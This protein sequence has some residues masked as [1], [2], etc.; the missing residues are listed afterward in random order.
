MLASFDA[1]EANSP[2]RVCPEC[3]EDAVVQSRRTLEEKGLDKWREEVAQL[4]LGTQVHMLEYTMQRLARPSA[5]PRDEVPESDDWGWV[6]FCRTDSRDYHLGPYTLA[7]RQVFPSH[8]AACQ[9]ALGIA[10]TRDPVVVSGRWFQLR[11][12]NPA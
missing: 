1:A 3:T 4:D 5:A 6:I 8:T 2:Y 11:K 10:E 9:H 12:G 7:T